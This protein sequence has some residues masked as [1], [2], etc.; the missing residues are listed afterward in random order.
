M[1]VCVCVYVYEWVLWTL[2][3]L[4]PKYKQETFV[5][6]SCVAFLEFFKAKW[7][8]HKKLPVYNAKSST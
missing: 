4:H 6:G 2:L 1:C 5:L 8:G 3:S 7:V